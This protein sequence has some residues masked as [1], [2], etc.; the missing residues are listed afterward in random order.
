MKRVVCDLL[1]ILVLAALVV[2]AAATENGSEYRCGY[3]TVQNIEINLVN[4]DAQVNLTYDVDNGPKFLIHLLGTSDLRAKV[5]DVANFENATI[6]EI[7]TDHAVLLV[8]G[9]AK[10]Y[11]DGTFRFFEHNFTVSVPELT[12][13]TPQEQRVYYNTTRFP[14]SIGYF[15]T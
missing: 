9:A 6:D 10:D 1:I 11:K 8:Q 15:R 5:L 3:M 13:K 4:E 12:V 14:G 2:P 7:G